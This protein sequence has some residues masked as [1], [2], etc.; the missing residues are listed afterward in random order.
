MIRGLFDERGAWCDDM[1]DM[2]MVVIGYFGGQFKVSVPSRVDVEDVLDSLQS[3][4][5]QKSYNFLDSLFTAAEARKAVFDIGPMK[6]SGL[7]GMSALFYQMFWGTVHA[8]VTISLCNVFYKIV[9]KTLANRL[10]LILGEAISDAQIAFVPGRLISV[11]A[12]IGFECLHVMRSKDRKVELVALKLDMSKAYDQVEWNFLAE[13]LLRLDFSKNWVRGL[14]DEGSRWRVGSWSVIRIFEDK[15]L[16]RPVNFKWRVWYLRNQWVH[17]KEKHDMGKVTSRATDFLNEF[18]GANT[19]VVDGDT[20]DRPDP[21]LVAEAMAILS[22]LEFVANTGLLPSIL[23]SD[24]LGVVNMI[25][26]D[27]VGSTDF[28]LVILD[29]KECIR[30]LRVHLV[31]FVSRNTNV[32]AHEIAKLAIVARKDLFWMETY[33]PSAER[34]VLTDCSL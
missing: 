4:L 21:P 23:E 29:I 16:Y 8:K 17:N 22:G 33:P 7:D 1:R 19:M 32:V 3:R 11:N 31:S 26:A 10:R 6:A 18:V 13:V 2:E 20:C 24:A 34:F 14:L 27:S 30:G 25:N 5:S 12:I 15:W 28:S 9:V